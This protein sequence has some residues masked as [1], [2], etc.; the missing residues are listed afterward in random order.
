MCFSLI[1]LTSLDQSNVHVGQSIARGIRS[2]FMGST[3]TNTIL[4]SREKNEEF[5]ILNTTPE[6]VCSSTYRY[7]LSLIMII[8]YLE[9]WKCSYIES[10]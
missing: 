10:H 4:K 2:K 8:F 1:I 6:K 3:K 9:E 5:E 7:V